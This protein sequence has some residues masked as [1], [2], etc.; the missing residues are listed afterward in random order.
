MHEF[1]HTSFSTILPLNKY[2]STRSPV[3]PL[4]Q[5]RRILA[6]MAVLTR[7]AILSARRSSPNVSNASLSVGAIVGIVVGSLCAVSIL[8][9]L[10]WFVRRR[11]RRTRRVTIIPLCCTASSD[12]EV[13]T[14]RVSELT[15]SEHP[16]SPQTRPNC[17]NGG[18][19][20]S[21]PEIP[22]DGPV[23]YFESPPSP[24]AEDAER[25]D[26]A[27]TI[28]ILASPTPRRRGATRDSSD[29]AF[30]GTGV[31]TSQNA[32]K[33]ERTSSIIEQ[34]PYP[35]LSHISS[36]G[37]RPGSA[38]IKQGSV[39]PYISTQQYHP[40]PQFNG[41]R[42]G[43]VNPSTSMPTPIRMG[44]RS[45]LLSPTSDECPHIATSPVSHSLDQS[46][47]ALWPPPMRL[48][49]GVSSEPEVR[50]LGRHKT[51]ISPWELEY[52]PN[53]VIFAHLADILDE[54]P[55][56]SQRSMETQ[57]NGVRSIGHEGL[58]VRS[59]SM[60]TVNFSQNLEMDQSWNAAPN[61]EDS[62]L[63][64]PSVNG[65][66]CQRAPSLEWDEDLGPS[67]D[68]AQLLECV[69]SAREEAAPQQLADC[70]GETSDP[71]PEPQLPHARNAKRKTNERAI[72]SRCNSLDDDGAP[73][74]TS[75]RSRRWAHSSRPDIALG[76]MSLAS[77]SSV[78]NVE[79]PSLS[80][81]RASSSTSS[82]LTSSTP[83]IANS[84]HES[85]TTSPSSSSQNPDATPASSAPFDIDFPFN[86]PD[87]ERKYRTPGELRVHEN[88]KHIRRFGCT[89]CGKDFNLGA[90]LGRHMR[91][92]HKAEGL[93]V[94][95]GD[96]TSV[97]RCPNVGC[98]NA[99]KVWD[100][101]DNLARHIV[102]CR[103]ATRS[104]TA[105]Q[106]TL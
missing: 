28:H 66:G 18:D 31:V 99:D 50:V 63:S 44:P 10:F 39:S 104:R 67:P 83:E 81:E 5:H 82:E 77:E 85:T 58:A 14:R 33:H 90:D 24:P 45:P 94:V 40:Y 7:R 91:T 48:S 93:D 68:F 8:C 38:R 17:Y 95:D 11:Q 64:R 26:W 65:F 3:L 29:V 88:R 86:C 97:L 4:D 96:G 43:L 101:R 35:A 100:R 16:Y 62:C 46:Y 37:Q 70:M 92:V 55:S 22:P 102:R 49:P 57:I 30:S 84:E 87:C 15:G 59:E 80:A 21:I 79:P 9:L 34:P 1:T 2:L 51:H 27:T 72:S 56:P 6:I 106:G 20:K 78:R 19:Y 75:K 71:R 69:D 42:R 98:R 47:D 36:H 76:Q 60:E 25:D 32:V 73:V 41:Q 61:A 74:A 13:E 12:G 23:V 103:K 52:R 53:P 105:G 89:V 54:S